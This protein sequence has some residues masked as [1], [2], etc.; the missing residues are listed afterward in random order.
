MLGADLGPTLVVALGIPTLVALLRCTTED[1][2]AGARTADVEERK[3]RRVEKHPLNKSEEHVMHTAVGDGS[4]EHLQL[5]QALASTHAKNFVIAR[6]YGA[7]KIP[8]SASISLTRQH[9]Q[10]TA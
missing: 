2:D 4:H 3:R 6:F 1:R 5:V 10:G 7:V 8:P 9:S